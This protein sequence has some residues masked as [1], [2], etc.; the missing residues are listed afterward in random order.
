MDNLLSK[1]KGF[2]EEYCCTVVRVGALEDVENSDNLKK[3]YI[4]G[5]SIVVNKND[6]K[7]GDIMLYVSNEC[8]I[9]SGFLFINNM[10][11]HYELN[12]NKAEVEE[13]LKQNADF[14]NT[15]EFK[16][17][18][19]YFGDNGR[20]RMI[21]LR[22]CP[23]FGVLLKPTSF[24]KA[25]IHS[26]IKIDW[27]ALVGTDF[28][29]VWNDII[30][31]KAYVPPMRGNHTKTISQ[32]VSKWDRFDRMVAGQFKLHYDTEMLKKHLDLF[33]LDTT[34]D[35]TIKIHG[36]S[37]ICGNL[38]V[39][40]PKPF[41]RLKRLINNVFKTNISE[42]KQQYGMVVSSRKV[43]KNEWAN[44]KHKE[45]YY[46]VD[47]WTEYGNIIYPY[48]PKGVTVYGEIFGYLTNSSRMIQKDYDYG[49]AVGANKLMIYR[50]TEHTPEGLK[51]YSISEV[52]EFTKKIYGNMVANND[53]NA[54]RIFN[55]EEV[56]LYHGK[57]ET[58]VNNVDDFVDF[59]VKNCNIEKREPMCNNN[60][61]REGVVVRICDDAVTEAFKLKGVAF[62]TREAK[63]IDGGEV[64]I[65][66]ENN[67]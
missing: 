9:D 49:N 22:G 2:S 32:K 43:I 21:R 46:G 57:L 8:Q 63:N 7:E 12:A 51:E 40:Y 44:T 1:S 45:G 25:Y 39:N 48:I 56:K 34:I 59:L 20:V 31:V 16:K 18:R 47:I 26:D 36:T 29:T 50:V 54:D 62:L 41:Y 6:V 55:I 30:F 11:E 35:V 42:F 66:M 53:V 65:E 58:L 67:L 37:F 27:N 24:E 4:N 61:P 60:V 38:L 23:S 13:K 3:T 15:D 5:E 19:G 33:K 14:K 17:M 52:I 28:D 64:D 10:Y